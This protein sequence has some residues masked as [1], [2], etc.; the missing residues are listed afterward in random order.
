MVNKKAWLRIVEAFLAILIILGVL[1]F[2]YSGI[3]ERPSKSEEI[4]NLEKII[5]D[6]ISFSDSLRNA[7]L[8]EKLD[9]VSAYVGDRLDGTSFNYSVR[10]CELDDIC[11]LPFYQKEYYAKDVPIVANLSTYNPKKVKLFI[12]ID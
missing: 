7:V 2:I 1:I 8:S 4:Y 11:N 10:I 3:T 12:W 9:I 6:E 5:L